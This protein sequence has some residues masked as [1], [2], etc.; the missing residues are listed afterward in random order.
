MA[1]NNCTLCGNLTRDP[2]IRETANSHVMSF[3]IAVNEKR[4]NAKT[5]VWEDVP[6]YFECQMWG[7]RTKALVK[8][9]KKGMKVTVSGSLKYESWEKDGQKRSA[10]CINVRDVELP[11]RAEAQGA[12][13][14]PQ[15][16]QDGYY[17]TP[18]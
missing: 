18:F 11:S 14:R 10:V 9:L 6:N 17:P 2:E 3:G 15:I 12:Q 16:P 13:P 8:F 5:G 1:I 7:D 4:R